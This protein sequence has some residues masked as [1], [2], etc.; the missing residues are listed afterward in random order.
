MGETLTA[1]TSGI[2]DDD[3]LDNVAFAYQWLRGDADIAGATGDTYTLVE[4]DEGQTIKVR[5]SFTDD[6]GNPETLTSA[7]TRG[8]GL[9]P[10]PLTV[11]TVVDASTDSDT[12]LG[13]AGWT[14]EP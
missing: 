10:G 3:G 8:G 5:V 2:H 7:P 12:P 11:F 1:D 4:A 9:D 14:E 13:G 6:E